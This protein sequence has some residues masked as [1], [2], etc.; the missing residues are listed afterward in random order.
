MRLAVTR[1]SAE[2][3]AWLSSVL[4]ARG[5]SRALLLT[6]EIGDYRMTQTSCTD[7]G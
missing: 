2:W 3:V 6:L 4:D 7:W 5:A 1:P